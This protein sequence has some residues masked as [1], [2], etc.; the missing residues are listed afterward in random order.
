MGT[1]SHIVQCST[2]DSYL[3]R[4]MMCDDESL[5]FDIKTDDAVQSTQWM[6]RINMCVNS[7]HVIV[8]HC[9]VSL[10]GSAFRMHF[11]NTRM[12]NAFVFNWNELI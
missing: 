3:R 1:T 11:R 7:E 9:D 6:I 8:G 10:N 12:R 4:I 5:A 2:T